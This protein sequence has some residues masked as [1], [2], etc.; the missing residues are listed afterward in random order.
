MMS[1]VFSF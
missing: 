1:T